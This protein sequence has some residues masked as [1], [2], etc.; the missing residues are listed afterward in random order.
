MTSIRMI[1]ILYVF[2]HVNIMGANSFSPGQLLQSSPR[3]DEQHKILWRK[4]T[5]VVFGIMLLP[6]RKMPPIAMRWYFKQLTIR[7]LTKP[8][9]KRRLQNVC[10]NI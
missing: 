7:N 5:Y 4:T 2:C 1:H 8:F 3:E 6:D 10:S 9:S